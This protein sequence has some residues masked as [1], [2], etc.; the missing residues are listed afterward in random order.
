MLYAGRLIAGLGVGIESTIV[1]VLLS[2]IA[3]TAIRG[4]ITTLHQ[5]TLV[6]GILAAT[7]VGFGFVQYVE[8][9]WRYVQFFA[10]VPSVLQ[11][12]FAAFLPES[13]K[14]LVR[15][16]QVEKARTTLQQLR[17][18]NANVDVELEQIE[19][20]LKDEGNT[21]VAV[22]WTDVFAVRRPMIVGCL[23]MTFQPFSGINAVFGYSTQIFGFAGVDDALLSA[24]L[25]AGTNVFA[26]VIAI[27][28]IDR[29]GRKTLL[30]TG[31]S[32]MV[33]SE[34]VMGVVLLALNAHEKV[35]GYLAVV[36]TLLFVFGFAIGMGAACWTVMS[37][38]LPDRIRNK[39]FSV[40]VAISWI[41]N[42]AITQ[43][44]LSW[45]ELA[46][47]VSKTV[48]NACSD[49]KVSTHSFLNLHFSFK[50]GNNTSRNLFSPLILYVFFLILACCL[51]VVLPTG[52][53]PCPFRVL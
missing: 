33:V 35:Q 34:A 39:A 42:L 53:L 13:P 50:Y 41:N 14:W 48:G 20:D 37:E 1:P 11:L 47:G 51:G 18:P 27:F 6:I 23:L 4:T 24:L 29:L 17:G 30:L 12:F 21:D 9:G 45:I 40:F 19:S 31:T 2:E 3:P 8:Q 5:M 26:T 25:A 49:C 15:N 52:C 7:L 38:I 36:T 44:T 16:K 43:F 46:G 22:T 10:I 28:L 32:L